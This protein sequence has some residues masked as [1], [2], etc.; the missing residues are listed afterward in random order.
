MNTAFCTVA[1]VA[2]RVGYCGQTTA[3][4]LV[5]SLRGGAV[6][7]SCSGGSVAVPTLIGHGDD[8]PAQVGKYVCATGVLQI[9]GLS[10]FTTY[11]YSVTVDGQTLDGSF[12]TLPSSDVV[13]WGFFM[14]TCEHRSAGSQWMKEPIYSRVRELAAA[15]NVP[16]LFTAHIDDILYADIFKFFGRSQTDPVT[17]LY[18]TAGGGQQGACATGLQWDYAVAWCGWLGLLPSV[19][20]LAH[21]DRK[22]L[23]RNMPFWAI[24]GDHEIGGDHGSLVYDG[25]GSSSVSWGANRAAYNN[26]TGN[27]ANLE[28]KAEAMYEAFC[29]SACAPP[30]Q[31]VDGGP[32][33][34]AGAQYWGVAVGPMRF[35]AFDRN[36]YSQPYNA[37]DLGDTHTYGRAGTPF[38]GTCAGATKPTRTELGVLTDTQPTAQLGEPQL[39]DMLTWLD[40]DEPF[41]VIFAPNGISRHNQPWNEMWPGEFEDYIGRATVGLM[42]NSKTNGTTGYSVHLKGDTHGLGVVSYHADGTSAGLGGASVVGGELWEICPGTINGSTIGGSLFTGTI[43]AGGKLR[44]KK[45]GVAQGDR[46]LAGVLHCRVY[47]ARSPKEF[48]VDLV[49]LPAKQVL[50]S[51]YQAVG[52]VGNQFQYRASTRQKVG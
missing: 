39:T 17:G 3:K 19:A 38:F 34:Q 21:E 49:E 25:L 40:N 13:D 22:W 24:W 45:N 48:Q 14:Q 8:N 10:P 2:V 50:W 23:M 4:I 33:S 11:T 15:S 27:T 5:A 29:V 18:I 20:E 6:T 32:A 41:K 7:A 52:Q 9:T 51:G 31:M 43:Y 1:G 37:C 16:V 30:R 26:G 28:A 42:K 36:K 35:F 44:Y 47:G 12:T 46:Q